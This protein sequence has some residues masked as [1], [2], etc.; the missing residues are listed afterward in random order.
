MQ[1]LKL[2][3]THFWTYSRNWLFRRNNALLCCRGSTDWLR[4]W[5]WSDL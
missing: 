4:G 3:F 1:S 2:I 5:M